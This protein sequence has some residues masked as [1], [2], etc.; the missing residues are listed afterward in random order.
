[1]WAKK[2]AKFKNIVIKTMLKIKKKLIDI[3]NHT[4]VVPWRA[5]S[6]RAAPQKEPDNWILFFESPPI[7]AQPRLILRDRPSII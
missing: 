1:M 5:S 7:G 6:W 2:D 3:F 4:G